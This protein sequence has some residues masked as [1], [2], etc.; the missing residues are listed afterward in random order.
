MSGARYALNVWL[1]IVIVI[2]VKARP[3]QSDQR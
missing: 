3:R 2:Q 1:S